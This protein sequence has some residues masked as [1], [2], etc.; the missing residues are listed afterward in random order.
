MKYSIV[1]TSACVA[2]GTRLYVKLSGLDSQSSDLPYT[3]QFTV[4]TRA[5]RNLVC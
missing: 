3:Y 5:H 2:M 1:T 4:Q